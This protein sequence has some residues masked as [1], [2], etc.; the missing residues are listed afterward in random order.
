MAGVKNLES[1]VF[2]KIWILIDNFGQ[3]NTAQIR[4]KNE[5]CPKN[6]SSTISIKYTI[7]VG[8]LYQSHSVNN[9]F[10]RILN[11]STGKI[12]IF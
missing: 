3:K 11:T 1:L 2:S 5:I 8:G 4:Y 9:D 7:E 12:I 10:V 6:I